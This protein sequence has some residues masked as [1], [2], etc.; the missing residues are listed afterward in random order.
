MKISV[1]A[2]VKYTCKT[3][4]HFTLSFVNYSQNTTFPNFFFP[5]RTMSFLFIVVRFYRFV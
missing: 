4:L 2:G 1:F 3:R 5:Y